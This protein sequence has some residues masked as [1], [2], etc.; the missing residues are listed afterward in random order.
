MHASYLSHCHPAIEEDVK[1]S[2]ED[3]RGGGISL[4][5]PPFRMKGIAKG[6]EHGSGSHIRC[7]GGPCSLIRSTDEDTSAFVEIQESF[8]VSHRE[9][10][11]CPGQPLQLFGDRV[12]GS[13]NVPEGEVRWDC[14]RHAQGGSELAESPCV[15]RAG[16]EN[17]VDCP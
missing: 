9:A 2:N 7:K 10:K 8:E 1:D 17:H 4:P 15:S 3:Q 11:A 14:S 12:E 6:V 5:N 13:A 16:C